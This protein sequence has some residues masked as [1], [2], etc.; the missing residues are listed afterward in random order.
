MKFPKHKRTEDPDRLDEVRQLPCCACG[1]DWGSEAHHIKGTKQG[2]M[3]CKVG[4]DLTIPLCH[5]CHMELHLMGHL[6]WE[7][8][9]GKQTDHLEHTNELIEQRRALGT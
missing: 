1:G 7:S 6:T 9:H 8:I 2:G 5:V 4:D 3:G